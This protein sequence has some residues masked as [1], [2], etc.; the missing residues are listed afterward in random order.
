MD[1]GFTGYGEREMADRD[2]CIA[3]GEDLTRAYPGYMWNVGCNHQAGVAQI[4]LMMPSDKPSNTTKGF[5]IHL[6]TA[7]G[8]GGQKKVLLAG[9]EILERWGLPRSRSPEDMVLR[10]HEHGLDE[11]NMITK[12]RY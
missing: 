10:A 6:S 12:S 11:S 5:L 2:V 3:I 1:A 9:G 7:L 4:M 8:P